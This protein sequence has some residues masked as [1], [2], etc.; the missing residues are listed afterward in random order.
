MA[1]LNDATVN[2]IDSGFNLSY[3]K[4][5]LSMDEFDYYYDFTHQKPLENLGTRCV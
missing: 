2:H 1:M 5:L 4:A 3:H